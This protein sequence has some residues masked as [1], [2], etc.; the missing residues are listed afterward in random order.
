MCF[1]DN[2][3]LE[4]NKVINGTQYYP[5]SSTLRTGGTPYDPSTLNPRTGD[6]NKS[7]NVIPD[8][9]HKKNLVTSSP[10]PK[11]SIHKW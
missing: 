2:S 10:L 11:Y 1:N 7:S 9:W 4:Q 6:S 5:T 8:K 3:I